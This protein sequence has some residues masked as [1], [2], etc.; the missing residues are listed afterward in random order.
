MATL[1][2]Y[3]MP[4]STRRLDGLGNI[5]EKPH[6]QTPKA[7]LLSTRPSSAV[8]ASLWWLCPGAAEGEDRVS[9]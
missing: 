1:L 2:C 8:A 3:A 5:L 9:N 7:L 4:V 6:T